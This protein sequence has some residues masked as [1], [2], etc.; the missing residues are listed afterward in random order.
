MSVLP[1]TR[2]LTPTGAS[3]PVWRQSDLNP[4]FDLQPVRMS[5]LACWQP[6]TVRAA[7]WLGLS[8]TFERRSVLSKCTSVA[9]AS[10]VAQLR[11]NPLAHGIPNCGVSGAP[12]KLSL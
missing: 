12:R 2:K 4:R 7:E 6:L 1:P 8:P 11:T 3:L 5:A 9:K 10:Y